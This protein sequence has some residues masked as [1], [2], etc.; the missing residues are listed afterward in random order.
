MKEFKYLGVRIVEQM[1]QRRRLKAR[2]KAPWV[3]WRDMSFVLCDC[4][5][6][7]KLKPK[8]YSTVVRPSA[9]VWC[10]YMGV[11]KGGGGLI[12]KNKNENAAVD[13]EDF[14]DI[15]ISK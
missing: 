7:Q 15:E 2:V 12:S 4:K 13:N 1:A 9:I 3:K 10:R 6:S 14:T 5:M 8:I 11:E